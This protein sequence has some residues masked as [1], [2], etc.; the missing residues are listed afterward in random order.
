[1]R[2][3]AFGL[4][5]CLFVASVGN[6]QEE[7]L[8]NKKGHVV[9]PETGDYALGFNAVPILTFIGNTFNGNTNNTSIGDDKFASGFGQNVIFGKYFLAPEK[10][11][12]ID[13]R[14]GLHSATFKNDVISDLA[15]SPDSLVVDKAKL[16]NQNYVIGLGHEWRM[17]T[18]RLQG[19]VGGGLFY[20]FNSS[21]KATYDYGN[22]F[23]GGN[24]SPLSTIWDNSGN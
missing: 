2:K 6:A 18:G 10:A 13:F 21:T 4:M 9:L 8:K 19:V 23:S 3:L 20:G 7:P 5:G 17:G 14:F 11:V 1:M 22:T 15:N 24:A 16:L 12:R